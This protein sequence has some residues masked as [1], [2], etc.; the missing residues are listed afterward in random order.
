MRNLLLLAVVCGLAASE[1]QAGGLGLLDPNARAMGMGGAYVAQASDPT[2]ILYNPGGLALLK[3]KKGLSAGVTF[4]STREATFQGLPPGIGAGTTAAQKNKMATLPYAFTSAPFSPRIVAGL[5]AYTSY[6]TRSEWAEP[7]T[8]SGRYLATSSELKALDLAP[9]FSMALTPNIGIGA[10]AIYRRTTIS[11]SRRI[12]ATLSGNVVDVA[13]AVMETDT[14]SSTGWHAGIL[15]RAGEAFSIG[16]THRSKMSVDFEGAGRLTQIST[17]NTQLDQLVGASFPFNQDLALATAFDFPEQT[18]AGI[19]LGLGPVLIEVDA[20]R[21]N[22]QPATALAF[23]FPNDPTLNVTYP[24]ALQE[25]TSYRGGLRYRFPTGPQVR[26][27]YAIEKSPQPDQTVGAF[28]ADADRNTVTLGFGLD[29]LDLAVG[30]TK[31]GERSVTTN[32]DQFN[33]NYRGNEWTAALT[34]TK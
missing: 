2:A 23:T 14:T 20:T 19:A 30:W 7:A 24:L 12:G 21:A 27:G 34:I 9:T 8:F 33:G 1:L 11:G 16:I 15:V 13:D 17:G 29:W 25:T 5:G 6:N 4:S 22:W 3:K 18:T 31:F 26:V 10:G 32:V 28:L